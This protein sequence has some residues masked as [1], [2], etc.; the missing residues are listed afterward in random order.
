MSVR[1]LVNPGGRRLCG[2][3][4][5]GASSSRGSGGVEFPTFATRFG[6]PG[7]YSASPLNRRPAACISYVSQDSPASVQAVAT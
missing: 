2:L 6:H 5:V 3:R 1:T 4:W 7:I